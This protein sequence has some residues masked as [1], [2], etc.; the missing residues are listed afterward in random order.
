MRARPIILIAIALAGSF[1]LAGCADFDMP[2]F[3]GSKKPLPGDRKLVFPEGVPG[4]TQ[5]VPS[6][7]RRG[8]QSPDAQAVV[9]PPPQAA[10]EPPKPKPKPKPKAAAAPRPAAQP[11]ASQP[12]AQQQP[13]AAPWPAQ[14]QQQRPAAAA[15]WPSAQP[16]SAQPAWPSS[17]TVQR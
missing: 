9:E 5:G 10:P 16:Q 11:Q 12:P 4:V 3:F 17:G 8:A 15:P 7:Y 2:D 1:A 6:E 14:Q 13:A